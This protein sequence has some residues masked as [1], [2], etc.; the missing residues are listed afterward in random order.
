M[1]DADSLESLEY[2]LKTI[3][4]SL[5]ADP[6]NADL[7]ELK[8]E[9]ENLV[10]LTKEY[11]QAGPSKQS[12]TASTSST[13]NAQAG[14]SR[15]ST[16]N[17]YGPTASSSHSHQPTSFTAG[18]D[19]LAKWHVDGK[20]YP[21]RIASISGSAADPVYTVIFTVD[22]STEVVRSGDVKALSENRKRAYANMEESTGSSSTT[23][24]DKDAKKAK[25]IEKKAV[26]EDERKQRVAEQV[27]KQSS[28]QNFA[29]KAVK[30][31]YQGVGG[32][33]MFKTP[34]NPHG[35]V[36]V[37]GSGKGMTAAPEKKRYKL[38]EATGEQ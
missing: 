13:S 1:A 2:Q 9:M 12:N 17:H 10:A 27:A 26:K 8:S 37:V 34:D 29:K 24:T 14:P 7:L 19:V 4:E 3:N 30:K 38:G 33:S 32:D 11:Q 21:A 23:S 15:P 28:W 20:M 25:K 16:S 6:S 31:G 22:K 5:R 18:T 36:G 35:R